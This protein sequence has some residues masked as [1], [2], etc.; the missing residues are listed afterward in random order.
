MS[1][2]RLQYNVSETNCACTPEVP[3]HLLNRHRST[4]F[5]TASRW[6]SCAQHE[7][8][9]HVTVEGLARCNASQSTAD[10]GIV[11]HADGCFVSQPFTV[12]SA[13]RSTLVPSSAGG[14]A[15]VSVAEPCTSISLV[16]SNLGCLR[17]LTLRMKTS[18]SG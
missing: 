14:G 8:P 16:M 7:V 15:A 2:V 11:Q 1:C 17:V 6:D 18:L 12:Y 10:G 13:G 9:C 3:I 5:L 4:I